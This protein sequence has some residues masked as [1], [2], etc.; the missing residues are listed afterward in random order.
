MVEM[1]PLRLVAQVARQG[2]GIDPWIPTTPF[3]LR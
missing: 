3:S 2:T 1:I